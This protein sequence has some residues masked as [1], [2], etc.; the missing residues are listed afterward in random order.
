MFHSDV[1]HEQV[2]AA[3]TL[4]ITAFEGES[5]VGIIQ[6]PLSYRRDYWEYPHGHGAGVDPLRR[7]SD[8]GLTVSGP[9]RLL[10]A[11]PDD[12]D[13]GSAWRQLRLQE[14]QSGR[15]VGGVC[16]AHG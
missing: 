5:C 4:V 8:G 3:P 7:S 1:L 16:D 15:W 9:Q 13:D 14:H 6:L 12:D 2:S 11:G 10:R